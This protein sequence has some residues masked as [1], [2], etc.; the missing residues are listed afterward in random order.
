[1]PISDTHKTPR[2][3]AQ[4][5]AYNASRYGYK[6]HLCRYV[7]SGHYFAIHDSALPSLKKE[8]YEIVTTYSHGRPI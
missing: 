4:W 2:Q 8:R 3:E 1:M 7:F 5:K 6:T